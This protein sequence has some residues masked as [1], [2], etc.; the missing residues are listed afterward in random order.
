MVLTELRTWVGLSSADAV[1]LFEQR[2]EVEPHWGSRWGLKPSAME[3]ILRAQQS[4]PSGASAK[5]LE[6]HEIVFT[7]AGVLNLVVS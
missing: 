7:P 4:D 6:A 3:A 2:E 1:R 5:E